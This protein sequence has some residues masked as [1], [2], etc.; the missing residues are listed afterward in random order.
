[1]PPKRDTDHFVSPRR[2]PRTDYF[3]M[4]TILLLD[5]TSIISLVDTRYRIFLWIPR[6]RYVVTSVSLCQR[7]FRYL[8]C[9][10]YWYVVYD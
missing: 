5:Y 2:E 7:R 3:D 4:V 1:M 10:L 8:V 6:T 9:G